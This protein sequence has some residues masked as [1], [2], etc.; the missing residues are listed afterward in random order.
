MCGNERNER[1]E[2]NESVL[3]YRSPC[4]AC[5]FLKSMSLI[6]LS[7]ADTVAA[8]VVATIALVD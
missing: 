5:F 6:A 1:N 8:S 7:L 2:R 4:M 3:A